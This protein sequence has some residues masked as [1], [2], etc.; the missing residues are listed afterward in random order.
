MRRYTLHKITATACE[1]RSHSSWGLRSYTASSRNHYVKFARDLPAT[2]LPTKPE[3]AIFESRR[4]C[5]AYTNNRIRYDLR[6]GS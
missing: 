1:T 4:K 6:R 5:K 2:G 3:S